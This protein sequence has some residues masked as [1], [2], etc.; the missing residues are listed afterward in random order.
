MLMVGS[1]EGENKGEGLT[2]VPKRAGGGSFRF[3][4]WG[5]DGGVGGPSWRKDQVQGGL[6]ACSRWWILGSGLCSKPT[7][8]SSGQCRDGQ[9][10]VMVALRVP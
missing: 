3:L 9:G 2:T 1:Q 5:W 10:L 8:T 7:G 6:W 4:R